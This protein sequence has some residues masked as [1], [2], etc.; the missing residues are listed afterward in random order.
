MLLAC[1]R[2]ARQ[3][4]VTLTAYSDDRI[5]CAATDEHTDRLLFYHEP[6]PEPVGDLERVVGKRGVQK[7][8]GARG[9][10]RLLPCAC[11]CV[12]VCC[13]T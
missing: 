5:L 10:G 12:C 8:P 3:H 4:G 11:A 9:M 6:T 13:A 7:V 1:I 2:L